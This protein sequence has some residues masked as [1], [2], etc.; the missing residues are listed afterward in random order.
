MQLLFKR[1]LWE[2]LKF[3]HEIVRSGM[4]III[5]MINVLICMLRG[6]RESKR[7]RERQRERERE[8]KHLNKFR[9][10]KHYIIC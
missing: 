6:M 9:K 10:A 5:Q 3:E 1:E 7:D 8:Q 2:P 4:Q